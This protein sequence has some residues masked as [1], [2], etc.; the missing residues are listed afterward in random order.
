M[1]L[2]DK[3]S[4]LARY[5][6][7]LVESHGYFAADSRKQKGHRQ[8]AYDHRAH[9]SETLQKRGLSEKK[10]KNLSRAALYIP[11]EI[12]ERH[13]GHLY[14]FLGAGAIPKKELHTVSEVLNVTPESLSE[15]HVAGRDVLTT[16]LAGVAAFTM[17]DAPEITG[18]LTS[19]GVDI[20][21]GLKATQAS[22]RNYAYWKKD[23]HL[24]SLTAWMNP[25]GAALAAGYVLTKTVKKAKTKPSRFLRNSYGQ[26]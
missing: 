15:G 11:P 8:K 6:A 26:E 1:S 21:A 3:V 17:H 14:G 2:A 19:T 25:V 4:S 16:A 12:D 18:Y 10:A 22:V 20:Y 7:Y 23:T 13:V 24:P 9:V 5:S